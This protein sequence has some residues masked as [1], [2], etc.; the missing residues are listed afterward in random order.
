MILSPNIDDAD[1]SENLESATAVR[2]LIRR[3]MRCGLTEKHAMRITRP[4]WTRHGKSHHNARV[5]IMGHRNL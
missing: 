1:P 4:S 5:L 2:P 3:Y